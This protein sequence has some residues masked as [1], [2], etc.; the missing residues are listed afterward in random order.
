VKGGLKGSEA[1]VRRSPEENAR[2]SE[3]ALAIGR[4]CAERL[5]RAEVPENSD[6]LLFDERGLPHDADC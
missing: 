1:A 5:A 3:R 4:D 6:A 2:L